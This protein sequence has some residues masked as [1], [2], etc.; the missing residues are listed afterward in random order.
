M[1]TPEGPWRLEVGKDSFRD[2]VL[3]RRAHEYEFI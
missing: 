1:L 3:P 2:K